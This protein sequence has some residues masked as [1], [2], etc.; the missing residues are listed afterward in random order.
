MLI[1]AINDIKKL[2]KDETIKL[3][4]MFPQQEEEVNTL[5]FLDNIP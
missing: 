4:I 5:S 1:G 3:E 2:L